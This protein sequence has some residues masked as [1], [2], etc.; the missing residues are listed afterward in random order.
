[1]HKLYENLMWLPESG[2]K[3]DSEFFKKVDFTDLKKY[4]KFQL[5]LNDL[6]NF[7]NKILN[8]RKV[9]K[10]NLT[11]NCINLLILS[12]SLTDFIIPALTSTGLRFEIDLN[13]IETDF[14]QIE[15]TLNSEKIKSVIK[16]NDVI[17]IALDYRA[18]NFKSFVNDIELSTD[19]V[20]CAINYIKSIVN[21]IKDAFD[22]DPINVWNLDAIKN[23]M[24]ENGKEQ[25]TMT[26]KFFT[27]IN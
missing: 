14:N 1:M 16:S 5:D 6:C 24:L 25:I 23:S 11:D 15:Q 21:K 9:S 10:N 4:A 22:I 17:L 26:K 27:Y 18:F 13:I 19:Q 20:S 8:L 2:I 7:Y 12:N 3:F